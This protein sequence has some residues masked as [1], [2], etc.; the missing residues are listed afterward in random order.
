MAVKCWKWYIPSV[1]GRRNCGPTTY[2]TI[3][4]LSFL[5][6]LNYYRIAVYI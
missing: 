2:K 4:K 1:A 6:P 3:R 5:V